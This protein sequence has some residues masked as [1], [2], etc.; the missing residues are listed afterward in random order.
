MI[1]PPEEVSRDGDLKEVGYY[2]A[3]EKIIEI[4]RNHVTEIVWIYVNKNTNEI[5][6]TCYKNDITNNHM[7]L[8]HGRV[9][10]DCLNKERTKILYMRASRVTEFLKQL[11]LKQGEAE[12]VVE[13]NKENSKLNCGD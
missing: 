3:R 7:I 8:G 9:P 2:L 10:H 13:W 12:Y 11:G 1:Y 6:Y 4:L 5:S